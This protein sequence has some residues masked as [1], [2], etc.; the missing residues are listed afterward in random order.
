MEWSE[1]ESRA[2]TG[3]DKDVVDLD[4]V[5]IYS[6]RKERSSTTN[7]IT[8]EDSVSVQFPVDGWSTAL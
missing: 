1:N 7:N 4:P 3:K 6:R 2:R 8:S 5:K